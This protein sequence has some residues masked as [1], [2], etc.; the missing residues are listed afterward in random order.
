MYV[1]RPF[2][3]CSSVRARSIVTMYE[4]LRLTQSRRSWVSEGAVAALAGSSKAIV[5]VR[6]RSMSTL[7]LTFLSGS[8]VGK[9]SR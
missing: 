8:V 9:Q 1:G 7:S 6:D 2:L 5:V 3:R 4:L